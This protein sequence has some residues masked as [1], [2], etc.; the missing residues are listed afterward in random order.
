[1]IIGVAVVVIIILLV[2]ATVALSRMGSSRKKEAIADLERERESLHIPDIIE[3]VNEEVR[4][5]DIADL[6]G[7]AGID[8]VV[9]LKV[10]KRDRG[11]CAEASGHFLVTEGVEPAEATEDDVTFVCP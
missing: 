1:M 8:P 2:V 5:T 11:S 7:A 10:W 4:E 6:P 9:L 3:L